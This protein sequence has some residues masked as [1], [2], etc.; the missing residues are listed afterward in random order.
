MDLRRSPGNAERDRPGA[1]LA[2]AL[3]HSGTSQQ[4]RHERKQD[5]SNDIDYLGHLRVGPRCPR[6]RYSAGLCH[7]LIIHWVDRLLL[8]GCCRACIGGSHPSQEWPHHLG[9]PCPYENG[10]HLEYDIGDNSYAILQSTVDHIEAGGMA[11]ISS[12]SAAGANSKDLHD[13][14]AFAPSD[15]VKDDLASISELT[16]KIIRDNAI[17]TDA[18]T[19][20]EKEGKCESNCRRILH[21]G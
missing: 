6:M 10:A 7:H 12:S 15:N 8:D 13:V 19:T 5:A 16:N 3:G 21:R 4:H 11:P 14:P 2:P 17:D 1:G 9:R 20:L 18:L